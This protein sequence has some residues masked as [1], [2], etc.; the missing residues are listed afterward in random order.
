MGAG[1]RTLVLQPLSPL[2]QARLV[3]FEK[4]LEGT[5]VP[6]ESLR[7]TVLRRL[8]W[9]N[10]HGRLHKPGSMWF[11]IHR[12]AGTVVWTLSLERREA[13]GHRWMLEQKG[14]VPRCPVFLS[15]LMVASKVDHWAV[16]EGCYLTLNKHWV[17]EPGLAS[18]PVIS[19]PSGKEPDCG[20][21]HWVF[22][23]KVQSLPH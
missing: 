3:S 5:C 14:L 17:L 1:I 10:G 9:P 11:G 21:E 12:M 16:Q 22:L 2:L 8:W 6:D 13:V 20:R 18:T 4:R 19:W 7:Y 15:G 23:E